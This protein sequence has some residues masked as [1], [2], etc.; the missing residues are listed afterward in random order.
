MMDQFERYCKLCEMEERCHSRTVYLK[1]LASA[2]IMAALVM[3]GLLFN[4]YDHSTWPLPLGF[5][6]ITVMTLGSLGLLTLWGLDHFVFWRQWKALSAAGRQLETDA[7][8]TP[9]MRSIMLPMQGKPG[10]ILWMRCFYTAPLLV[11]IL[12]SGAVLIGGADRLFAPHPDLFSLDMH[13]LSIVLVLLQLSAAIGMITARPVRMP[14]TDISSPTASKTSAVSNDAKEGL[15]GLAKV[16]YFK[17]MKGITQSPPS[18]GIS[19]IVWS[20]IGAFIGIAAVAFANYN[21]IDETDLVMVI[22]S[23]GATAVLLYGAIKSPLAQPRNCLG[24]HIISAVIGVTC[25]KLFHTHMWIASSFAVATAIAAMHATK[26][27]HPP[28]GAT[29]LIAVIG[30]SKIH[31]L[32]YLYALIPA[33]LGAAIMLV[34]ALFVNNI[35]H[36]RRYPEFWI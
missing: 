7:H 24:G 12:L 17:K 21:I 36:R 15:D 27:L 1:V 3:A 6:L 20:W 34:V 30:S 23:F 2:W 28:G 29:A 14:Q 26:T 25:Y 19:E 4:A 5:L 33:G 35:H 18:V 11:F 22:G 31:N 10:P 16:G 8:D 32:G 13:Y 9:A